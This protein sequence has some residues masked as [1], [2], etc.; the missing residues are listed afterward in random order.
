MIK[1]AIKV[2]FIIL[3]QILILFLIGIFG[4]A[5]TGILS[6]GKDTYMVSKQSATGYQ[7][8][9]GIKADVL[10]EANEFCVKQGLIMVVISLKTKDGVPGRSYATAELIFRAVPPGDKENQ[11]PVFEKGAD[12]IIE[13]REK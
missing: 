13:I 12:T 3:I 4:C 9:V 7:S 1:W 6:V 5:S 2:D 10:R 11:R 8:A